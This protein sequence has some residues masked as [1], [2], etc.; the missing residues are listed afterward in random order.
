MKVMTDNYY[1][2]VKDLE[3]NKKKLSSGAKAQSA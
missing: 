2:E 1:W 3:V